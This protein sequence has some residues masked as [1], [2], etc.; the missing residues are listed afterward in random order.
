[1]KSN[2]FAVLAICFS[3]SACSH[4]KGNSSNNNEQSD[5]FIA[6]GNAIPVKAE[7]SDEELD[8]DGEPIGPSID[9]ELAK[10]RILGSAEISSDGKYEGKTYYLYGAEHLNLQNYYF[11]IPVVYN[12]A[13]KKWMNYFLNKGR[14][15]FERYS[16]RA[17]RYA[18]MM[19][20]ILEEHGLPRDLIFLAMAESG[21]Q[22]KAKSYAA[23][24][25][26]WQFMKYTGRTYGL[27][28]NWY[29]DERYDP[30]KATIAASRYLKKLYG[31][32]GEW[33][34]A[35][36][37]YNAGEGKVGRAIA[38][39]STEN[40][41]DLSKGKYLKAETKN[42]VPKIMALAIIGKNLKNF[43]FDDI[44]FHEPLDFEEVNIPGGTDLML[45]AERLGI[46]FEE[47]QILNPEI[48]RWYIPSQIKNYVLR[49]PVGY[50]EKFAQ[51]F[52]KESC[53]AVA[54]QT[55]RVGNK[56]ATIN[57]IAKK[58]KIKPYVL[59]D[60]N[61]GASGR[62]A[63]GAEVVLP[64]R[65]GQNLKGEMYADLY[66]LPRKHT[67]KK[68]SLKA[69]L[70]KANKKGKQASKAK[71]FYTV[72]KGDT[73][74]S[75]AKKTG[76]SVDSIIASNLTLINSRGIKAGDRLIIR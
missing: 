55:V 49:L 54:F 5:A 63:K 43:G 33:E 35:A 64:F 48:L 2:L 30:I 44:D 13:V 28:S 68:R 22:N 37:A 19:G 46:D 26:P 51:A 11:D 8:Q 65:V 71:A 50:K 74:W 4:L 39:Y 70:E 14:G 15:F 29:I 66:E 69:R 60:L 45:V 73:L 56:G 41:W 17:G 57:G 67:Y 72:K 6:S 52:D 7:L 1:M 31:D 61:A 58:F 38:R 75:V 16:A 10:H 32:F 42:Y 47:I 20:K 76:V 3:L 23:A 59:E 18:P 27:R 62:F 53:R 40:F 36:A 21:F 25:G 9:E 24:V 12:D 34:L